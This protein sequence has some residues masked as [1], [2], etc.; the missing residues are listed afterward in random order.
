MKCIMIVFYFFKKYK[1]K[2]QELKTEMKS[3]K[4]MEINCPKATG[5]TSKRR[6]MQ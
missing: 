6:E 2:Y 3:I 5:V 1:K 4:E